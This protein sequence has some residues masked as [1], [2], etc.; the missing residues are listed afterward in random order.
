MALRVRT[1]ALILATLLLYSL[2]ISPAGPSYAPVFASRAFPSGDAL[3]G[4]VSARP[5]PAEIA[6]SAEFVPAFVSGREIDASG[7]DQDAH[8]LPNWPAPA[9]SASVDSS[10]SEELPAVHALPE[11]AGERESAAMLAADPSVASPDVSAVPAHETPAAPAVRVPA[12]P[13]PP[14]DPL[15]SPG[16]PVRPVYYNAVT[17]ARILANARSAL[18]IPYFLGG[19]TT[20]GID[21]SAFISNA[22]GIS[23]HTTETL[24]QVAAPISKAELQPGDALNLPMSDDPRGIGHMRLFAGWA[25]AE[26][27]HM[28]AYEATPP[29]SVYHVIPYDAR[30]TPMRRVNFRPATEPAPLA[31]GGADARPNGTPAGQPGASPRPVVTP[32]TVPAKPTA[33][34]IPSGT[35]TAVPAAATATPPPTATPTPTFAPVQLPTTTVVPIPFGLTPSPVSPPAAPSSPPVVAITPS[36]APPPPAAAKTATPKPASATPPPAPPTPHPK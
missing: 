12:V 13:E 22:W 35:A 30:F 31:G 34:A 19:N 25:N 6:A 9:P 24:S 32:T 5:F 11:A 10:P 8:T 1:A 14:A 4:F 21:C 7:S 3:R 17:S 33:T 36:S 28:W 15:P 2:T 29:Q 18:G 23:W 16:P 26:R 27:M 20:A